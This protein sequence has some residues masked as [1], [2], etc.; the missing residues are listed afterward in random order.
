MYS[1]LPSTFAGY[2][3]ARSH[4]FR[5]YARRAEIWKAHED[6]QKGLLHFVAT[7]PRMPDHIRREMQSW[8]TCR[9]EFLDT[10]GWP[11]QLYIRE[12]RRMI[13][14]FVMTEHELLKRRPTPKPV[15]MGSYGIDSHN[16]QRYITPEGYVQNEGDIGVSTEGP[17]QIAYGSLT[18]KRDECVNLLVPVAASASHVAYGSL[19]MEPQYMIIGHA[20]GV[21]AKMAVERNAAVQEIDTTALTAKLKAQRAVFEYTP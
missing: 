13:G 18:P 19:R 9:D 1:T 4:K 11:H 3:A 12:A 21:A 5:N 16:V 10:G 14:E 2:L 20:A 6:Y 7:D 17:Y 15:G 8:G